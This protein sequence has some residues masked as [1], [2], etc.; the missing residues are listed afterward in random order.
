VTCEHALRW[1]CKHDRLAAPAVLVRA[2]GLAM[3][4]EEEEHCDSARKVLRPGVADM[5]RLEYLSVWISPWRAPSP[6]S[7][8]SSSFEIPPTTPVDAVCARQ[9]LEEVQAGV[10]SNLEAYATEVEGAIKGL[11]VTV[12]ASHFGRSAASDGVVYGDKCWVWRKAGISHILP[13]RC[14]GGKCGDS[15]ELGSTLSPATGADDCTGRRRT[16]GR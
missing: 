15:R 16:G 1:L 2:E 10:S 6:P 11:T 12:R 7:S 9:I 14:L 3:R 4:L 5:E 13:P 8:D